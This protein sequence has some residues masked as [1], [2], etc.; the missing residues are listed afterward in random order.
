LLSLRIKKEGEIAAST[1]Q[2]VGAARRDLTPD[3]EGGV[4]QIAD[5]QI[6]ALQMA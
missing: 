5:D 6:A 1:T 3:L 4:T 2:K